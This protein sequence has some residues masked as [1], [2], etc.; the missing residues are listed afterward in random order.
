MNNKELEKEYEKSLE[1][2]ESHYENFPVAS[3]LVPSGLRR[4]VSVIY[5]YARMADDLADEGN[6]QPEERIAAL[7][8]VEEDLKNALEGKAA[9]IFFQALSSTIREKNL[10]PVYFFDLLKAFRQDVRVKRYSTFSELLD[11]CRNS[12]NPVGRIILELFDMRQSEFFLLSDKICTAL[13]LT[14]F[15]QDVSLDIQKGRIY[16]PMDE[17]KSFNVTEKDFELKKINTNFKE[18]IKLQVDRT[19][20]LFREGQK[21]TGFLPKPLKYEIK[22][23]VLGGERILSRIEANGYD[24]LGKRPRLGK[25]EYFNLLIK[26]IF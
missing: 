20:Q 26:S 11:Y 9:G 14:N 19:R 17:M 10:T 13:Q 16:I 8:Q 21:L 7:D 22:W 6:L 15:Y 1:V 3:F 4:H 23:T 18:L 25:L 2:A 12:A 5:N 24:V